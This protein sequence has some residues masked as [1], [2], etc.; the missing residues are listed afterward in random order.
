MSSDD[1]TDSNTDA[2]R[3][4]SPPTLR[5]LADQVRYQNRVF[6]RT[7]VA[8]FFTLVFPLMFLVLFQLLFGET[9]QTGAG[10][11]SVAQF[12]APA[13]GAFAAANATY[14]NIAVGTAT[15][16]DLGVLKRFRST[17]LPPAVYLLGRIVSS[18]WLA[19]LATLIMFG[20]AIGLFGVQA[21]TAGILPAIATFAVGVTAFSAL[22]FAVSA[23]AK[24]GDAAVAIT[25]ATLL[26]M[27]F[28]SNVFIPL[29]DPP[30]WLDTLGDL[31]PLK[32]F[33]HGFQAAF[34]PFATGSRWEFGDLAVLGAWAVVAMVLAARFF[35]WEAASEAP[36]EGPGDAAGAAPDAAADAP[37]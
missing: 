19:A 9:I 29:E 5:L 20:V 24:N 18:V 31:L 12:F 15:D 36:G 17:P 37:S 27:A 35:R 32:H 10:E 34:D 21:S 2:A 3:P 33:V 13:L 14:T 1:I 11:L 25:N 26:P 16:R 4:A 28:I 8:A 23:F 22:G 6:W 30:A 7:P